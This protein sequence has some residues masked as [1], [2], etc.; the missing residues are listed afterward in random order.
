MDLDI[1]YLFLPTDDRRDKKNN[2]IVMAAYF[3]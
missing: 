3:C 1:S 2:K